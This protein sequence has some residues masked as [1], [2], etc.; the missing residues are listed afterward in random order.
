MLTLR[1]VYSFLARGGFLP[2]D[3]SGLVLWTRFNSGITV[4]GAGVSQ[5]N[6]QSG[7]GNH[8]KQGTDTN[9]PSKE[10]DG[11]I[12]FDGVD[13]FLKADSFTLAQPETIYMLGKHVAWSS[14][15]TLFDGNI[16]N[17]AS[18]RQTQSSPI[19]RLNA[20]ADSG[21]NGNLA[22]GVYGVIIAVVNGASSL[23]QI[24]NTAKITGDYGA[25]I[26]SGFTLAA[27]GDNS[28]FSNIQVKEVLIYSTAH[29]AATRA[30]VI[31]Y[32]ASVG[33]LSI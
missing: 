16:L 31:N 5:W 22:I 28:N 8:L 21:N 15:N 20:G 25:L 3:L 26:M 6:D 18:V 33:G 4:T 30:K 11:S 7:N 24:N 17:R 19:L 2:N 14:G 10:S 13:N 12:L 29:D 32:L 9:R 23:L 27:R 1:G